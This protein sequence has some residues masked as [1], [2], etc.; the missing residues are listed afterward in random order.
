MQ[1]PLQVT[2]HQME[3]SDALQDTIEA[4]VAQ[5]EK[6]Y[7]RLMSCR[8][9]LEMAS[10]NQQSGNIYRVGIEAT[11]PGYRELVVSRERG[12]RQEHEDV[13]VAIR[14][15]FAAMERQLKEMAQRRQGEVKLHVPTHQ[16]ATVAQLFD[17]DD[18]GFLETSDNREI[19][20]HRN[21]VVNDAFDRL[22]IGI[23]VRFIEEQG[24][25]GSQAT[26]VELTK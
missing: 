26:M 1:K 13:Y 3:S 2:F 11:I 25:D 12:N 16:T 14:D 21:S 6:I 9:V 19:Y 8:V 10:R 5:L 23:E 4:H 24:D 15:A 7:D 18:F 17:G 20:F 22:E